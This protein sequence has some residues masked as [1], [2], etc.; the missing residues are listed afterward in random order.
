MS[1][2]IILDK[3]SKIYYAGDS[4]SGFVRL[5]GVDGRAHGAITG[6]IHGGIKY[7]RKNKDPNQKDTG[8]RCD[9]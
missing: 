6:R 5:R 8:F 4:V 7:G 9:H 2:Q 1:I 3:V